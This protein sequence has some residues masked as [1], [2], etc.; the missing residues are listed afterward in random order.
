MYFAE[1]VNHIRTFK[2]NSF[3]TLK[4][5]LVGEVMRANKSAVVQV[6]TRLSTHGNNRVLQ[7]SRLLI[8]KKYSLNRR[9]AAV[10]E[11]EEELKVCF[12]NGGLRVGSDVSAAGA[13]LWDCHA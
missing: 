10:K 3:K 5:R 8:K 9:R 2:T 6:Q 12:L 1:A 11:E 7:V 13:S 4:A